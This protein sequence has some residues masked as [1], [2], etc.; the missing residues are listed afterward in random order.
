[1]LLYLLLCLTSVLA[2]CGILTVLGVEVDRCNTLLLAPVITICSLVIFMGGLVAGGFSINEISPAAYLLCT[3]AA[4]LGAIRHG[5][6]V[7]ASWRGLLILAGLPL[8]ILLP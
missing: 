3:G 5:K 6:T 2:G 7:L 8:L 4:V 1:M